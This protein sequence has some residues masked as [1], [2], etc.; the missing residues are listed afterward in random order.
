[1]KKSIIIISAVIILF[2]CFF[3]NTRAQSP[4]PEKTIKPTPTPKT[5]DYNLAYPGMLPDSPIY[6]LKVLRDKITEK[7][8]SDPAKKVEFYLLQT[9]K[10][11]LAASML[12]DKKEV[13]LA[14][15]TA[16]KGEN[17]YSKLV[18]EYQTLN[19]KPNKTEFNKLKLAALKHQEVL[20]NI[21]KKVSNQ[22]KKTFNDVIYFSQVN[23]QNVNNLYNSQDLEEL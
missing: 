5:I 9:D 6:K 20:N 17:N 13:S 11:I 2:A 19:R 21:I 15:E 18:Y 22:D 10:Q 8:I 12:A 14:K 3:G 4:T 23:L 7:L 1:M 16:L